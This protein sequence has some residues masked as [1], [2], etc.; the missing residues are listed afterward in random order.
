LAGISQRQ[1]ATH[2]GVSY[3]TIRRL[4]AGGNAGTLPLTVI[5]HIDALLAAPPQPISPPTAAEPG[6]MD[7]NQATLLRRIDRGEDIRRHLT[8]TDR[9]LTLPSLI[10]AGHVHL[11]HTGR[12]RLTPRAHSSL[13]P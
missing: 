13:H 12:P 9:T 3:Q 6:S 11:D 2:A 1:L 7:T 10:N 4:E 8:R 5:Q